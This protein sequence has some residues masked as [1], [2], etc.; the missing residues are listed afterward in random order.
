MDIYS[1]KILLKGKKNKINKQLNFPNKN[2]KKPSTL[3]WTYIKSK[4]VLGSVKEIQ[5]FL[6]GFWFRCHKCNV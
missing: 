3:N 6:M 1:F 2:H 5:L 4:P